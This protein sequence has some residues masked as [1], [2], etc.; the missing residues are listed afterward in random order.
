[1]GCYKTTAR[2]GN[3][4]VLTQ[5]GYEDTPDNIKPEREIGKPVYGFEESV[6]TLWLQRGWVKEVL[7]R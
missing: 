3:H 1:M 5:K 6:P 2:K 4:F 7:R